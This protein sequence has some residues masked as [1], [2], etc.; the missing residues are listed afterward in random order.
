M[1]LLDKIERTFEFISQKNLSSEKDPF[2]KLIS[3]YL[4]ELF[5]VSFVLINKYSNK[6]PDIT[7]SV[8]IYGKGGFMPNL[9]YNLKFTPCENVIDHAL[10][11]YP[12]NS[13]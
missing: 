2:L 10:C 12:K 4:S 7:E 5:D 13:H 9:K 11:V 6:N 1:K 3:K 8:V